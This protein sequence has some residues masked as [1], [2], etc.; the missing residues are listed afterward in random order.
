ME[1]LL[2]QY[3]N[4]FTVLKEWLLALSVIP[5]TVLVNSGLRSLINNPEKWPK[6]WPVSWRQTFFAHHLWPSISNIIYVLGLAF[7]VELAPLHGRAQSWLASIFFVLSVLLGLRLVQ[8]T[9][10][11]GVEWASHKVRRDET[12]DVGFVPL[13]QNV[14]TIFVA[15]TGGIVVL[16]HFN[17]D[18]VSLVTALGVSSLAVGLAAKDTL[19]N[20]ISGFILIID[21]NL[22]PG[23]RI[24]LG[25]TVGDV[26]EIGLR[27]TNIR[28]TDNN[29]LIVPNSELV[30]NR[31]LNLSIPSRETSSTF[32][33]RVPCD[34][35]L[36]KIRTICLQITK[37]MEKLSK[38]RST[39]VGLTSLAEGHQLIGISIW[40]SDYTEASNAVS[41]FNEKLLACL[42]QEN[43]PLITRNPYA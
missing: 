7:I 15:L 30:N 41:D 18:V 5:A 29:T 36:A 42:S 43:I 25:G 35:P 17:Y 28:M 13:F 37:Q 2:S 38:D 39:W 24:N 21:R 19:S 32:Q 10:L 23:D 26:R 31:I 40:I 20:M 8:R 1:N 6:R 11:I 22:K 3:S 27:S 16:K 12:F 34:V 9:A 14:I 33:I 4:Y